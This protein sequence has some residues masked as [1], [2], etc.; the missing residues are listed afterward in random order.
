M[1]SIPA[2]LEAA[3][4]RTGTFSGCCC[5]QPSSDRRR[6]TTA[7]KILR[8]ST[9][10]CSLIRSGK[11]LRSMKTNWDDEGELLPISHSGPWQEHP[12]PGLPGPPLPGQLDFGRSVHF[13]LLSLIFSQWTSKVSCWKEL[14]WAERFVGTNLRWEEPNI[15]RR[16]FS[17]VAWSPTDFL[18]LLEMPDD[19]G[20]GSVYSQTWL[21]QLSFSGVC[22]F[23]MSWIRFFW[24]ESRRT[25]GTVFPEDQGGIIVLSCSFDPTPKYIS[26]ISCIDR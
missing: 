12:E 13:F 20:L 17:S 7:K 14:S 6:C 23:M 18:F 15:K 22:S 5:N 2:G 26:C 19:C 16:L 24:A 21:Q 9:A 8:S 10:D 4:S 25:W 11:R 3:Q 1:G